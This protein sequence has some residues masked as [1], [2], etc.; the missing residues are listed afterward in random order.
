MKQKDH[1]VKIAEVKYPKND[2]YK[3][4][5]IFD[6]SSCHNAYSED[7]LNAAHM[8]AKP[9]GK[10]P[11]LRDTVWNGKVQRMVFN[12]GVPKGLIQVLKERGRY[13]GKMKLEDMRKEISTHSD[14]R[15]EKTKLEHFLNN[16]GHVCIM[17]PKFHCEL[18]PIERCWG[19]AKRYT[20]AYTNYTFPKLRENI[21]KGLDTVTVDN[22]ANYFCK[23]RQYM[24]AYLEG[25]KPGKELENQVKK[26]KQVYKSHRR[27]G[28]ND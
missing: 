8:N 19:Q 4:I 11:C 3:V 16:R 21:P 15:D 6:N 24:F 1:A 23:A 28:V 10:Q 17:L 5:W 9:G 2:G 26:Y 13:N 12:L 27:V 25:F 7:A 14:F 18:N 22:I 20:R